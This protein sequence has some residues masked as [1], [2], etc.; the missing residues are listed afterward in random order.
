[1]I[2]K[3]YV[4]IVTNQKDKG[5][6]EMEKIIQCIACERFIRDKVYKSEGAC[7]VDNTY[8]REY[9]CCDKPEAKKKRKQLITK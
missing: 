6:K 2:V 1:M 3:D 8:T 4:K 9:R 7:D 5:G